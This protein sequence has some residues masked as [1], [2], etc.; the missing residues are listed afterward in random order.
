MPKSHLFPP[1]LGVSH[2]AALVADAD[3]SSGMLGT[4]VGLADF[5]LTLEPVPGYGFFVA[6]GPGTLA[7]ALEKV[8]SE[9]QA[10]TIV[11]ADGEFSFPD[12]ADLDLAIY[13]AH[14]AAI[15]NPHGV[16]KAQVG[17]GS[18]DN[19]PDANK[20]V[21]SAQNTAIAT[22]KTEA[23]SAAATDA[24]TKA[25]AA[26]TAAITA[27][28]EDATTK[29]SA[30]QTNA[31]N[32]AATDATT[33][34][35]AAQTAAITAAATDATTKANAAQT[36]AITAAATDATTKANAAITAAAT[37]ATIKANAALAAAKTYTDDNFS[38]GGG[39]PVISIVD[40]PEV[41]VTEN[42][43]I[44]GTHTPAVTG[45]L[46]KVSDTVWTST[47]TDAVPATG[48]FDRIK[49]GIGIGTWKLQRYVDGVETA[50]WTSYSFGN[51][52]DATWSFGSGGSAT[53]LPEFAWATE[54]L[55]AGDGLGQWLKVGP[56]APF[57]WHQWDG[58]A[59]Q[60]RYT[61]A[62]AY[63]APLQLTATLPRNAGPGAA[64]HAWVQFSASSYTEAT[65]SIGPDALDY[66][67]AAKSPAQLATWFATNW[68]ASALTT[69]IA[70]AGMLAF[71]AK[72][73]GESANE[74][75]I[76]TVGASISRSAPTLIGGLEPQGTIASPGQEATVTHSDGTFSIWKC[77]RQ[78]PVAWRPVS[79]DI[80]WDA[81]ASQWLRLSWKDGTL[82]KETLPDQ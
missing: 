62:A 75:L 43:L 72:D 41:T 52:V 9:N 67:G 65:V 38:S 26:Q 50:T 76:E 58:A 78:T 2:Y 46:I 24:T 55:P 5:T 64:A 6:V 11:L 18:A 70:E 1:V 42:I 30:A 25:G 20:P 19:T 68:S 16:T 45:P 79:S 63:N 56:A 28:A 39:L 31:I 40:V 57:A 54:V 14:L 17:L 44:T 49:P 32:A 4:I 59:W 71:T 23:I 3:F 13:N 74:Y 81:D 22:A 47:G 60:Y 80:I 34:A 8:L 7:G 82:D 37:D 33:K 27:A 48:V 15:T 29:A 36:A 53:G 69:V 66:M 35:S 21:S 77:A 73:E 51:P 10:I 61:D 12:S